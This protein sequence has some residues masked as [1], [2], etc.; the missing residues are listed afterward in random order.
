MTPQER[1]II[2][3]AEIQWLL[4]YRRKEC[5]EIWGNVDWLELQDDID[6]MNV[7]LDNIIELVHQT[8]TD[9]DKVNE[10]LNKL[11]VYVHNTYEKDTTVSHS[12]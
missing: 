5:E 2:V 4:D 10:L 9:K 8:Y 11:L 3:V 1:I 12:D 6:K 7:M